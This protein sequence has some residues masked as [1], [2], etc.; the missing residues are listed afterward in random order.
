[1]NC[2]KR[3]KQL[4]YSTLLT[5]FFLSKRNEKKNNNL[6]HCNDQ[7]F[8]SIIF[9]VHLKIASEFV[10]CFTFITYYLLNT[11]EFQTKMFQ[12]MF[13]WIQTVEG[14]LPCVR[15]ATHTRPK[16]KVVIHSRKYW[17]IPK[18]A[19]LW[20]FFRTKFRS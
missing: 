19:F 9:L 11:F 15:L 13:R 14:N 17:S 1:M 4:P 5:L 2:W 3:R 10:D 12:S 8:A 16:W 7:C 20:I 18:L 6:S